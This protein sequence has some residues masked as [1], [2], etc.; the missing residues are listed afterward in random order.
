LGANGYL[1]KPFTVEQ[2]AEAIASVSK[3]SVQGG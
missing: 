1:A 3:A 2:L